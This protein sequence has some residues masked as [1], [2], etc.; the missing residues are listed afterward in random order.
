MYRLSYT[1]WLHFKYDGD[2][3]APVRNVPAELKKQIH[4]R[5]TLDL[6]P[7]EWFCEWII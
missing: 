5:T 3:I 7:T 1:K 2:R 4:S 6:V